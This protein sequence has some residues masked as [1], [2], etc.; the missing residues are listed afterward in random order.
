MIGVETINT[1]QFTAVFL[2]F[3]EYYQPNYAYLSDIRNILDLYKSK[4]VSE[5][6]S[7]RQT[8]IYRLNYYLNFTDNTL[9][10]AAL[11]IGTI[12]LIAIL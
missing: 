3:A 9:V 2:S 10:V 6:S 11:S 7:V 4:V 12:T 1:I 5:Q 8:Q